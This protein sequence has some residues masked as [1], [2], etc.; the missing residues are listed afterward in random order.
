MI[1]HQKFKSEEQLDEFLEIYQNNPYTAYGF[2]INN[3]YPGSFTC[4]FK[5]R[6]GE[7]MLKMV[8]IVNINLLVNK[9]LF[10]KTKTY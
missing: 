9:V 8:C 7:Q 5:F 6:P 10:W 4:G 3:T 1:N 2:Y